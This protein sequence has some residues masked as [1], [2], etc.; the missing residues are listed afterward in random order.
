MDKILKDARRGELP[1]VQ[2]HLRRDPSPNS[3][4]L[5]PR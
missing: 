2:A 5:S 3:T 4:N 1:S